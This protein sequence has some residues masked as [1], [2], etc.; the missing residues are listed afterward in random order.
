MKTSELMAEAAALP[1]EERTRLVE[2]LL[3][4]LNPPESE[5]DAEW[6][7]V[8]HL[9]LDELRSGKVEAVPGELVFERV[10]QFFTK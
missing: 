5:I 1:V 6:T 9:R 2:N 4:S 10:R 8:A 3:S 7:T